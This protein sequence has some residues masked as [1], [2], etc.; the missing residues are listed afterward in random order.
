VDKISKTI[1]FRG[2]VPMGEQDRIRLKTNTGKTGYKIT[3]FQIMSTI[4][5]MNDLQV[6]SKIFNKDQ[7]GS[8]N[9]G[10]NFTDSELLAANYLV[11]GNVPDDQKE[12]TVI[13]DNSITNQDIFVTITDARGATD[14]MNYY[15][16]LETMPL[17]DLESTK[18]TLQSIR[19]ATS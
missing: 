9:A 2:T 3:Q 11:Q 12:Q 14:P 13:F 8:I 10:V 1:S 18:L 19:T 5:G 16:E 15:I 7:T 17:S 6:I 4:P